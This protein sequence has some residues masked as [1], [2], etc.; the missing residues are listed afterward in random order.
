[1]LT[2]MISLSTYSQSPLKTFPTLTTIS[3]SALNSG[4]I[5]IQAS[6][7]S[8]HLIFV[9]LFPAGKPLTGHIP[10]LEP[11]SISF[12]RGIEYGLMQA[13]ATLYLLDSS[14][15]SLIALSVIVGCKSEWSI[16][17]AMVGSETLILVEDSAILIK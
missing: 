13:V 4:P 16:I 2:A 3:I 9:V 5:A 1:M 15:P 11:L 14:S 6:R 7:A 10:T 17:L 8:V 12:A